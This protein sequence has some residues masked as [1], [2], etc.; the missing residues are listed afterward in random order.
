MLVETFSGDFL[1]ASKIVAYSIEPNGGKDTHVITA[2]T[3]KTMSFYTVAS[4][5]TKALAASGM[6]RLARLLAD[7]GRALITQDDI[8]CKSEGFIDGNWVGRA[9][10]A[11]VRDAGGQYAFSAE[12]MKWREDDGSILAEHGEDGSLR[13][14]WNFTE[15]GWR[16]GMARREEPPRFM[17]GAGPQKIVPDPNAPALKYRLGWKNDKGEQKYDAEGD[18]NDF[19]SVKSLC[20]DLRERAF[21]RTGRSD[22]NVYLVEDDGSLTRM[23]D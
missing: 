9:L 13:L 21:V 4:F 20:D 1:T 6:R 7:P 5:E 18:D 15:G 22:Y 14:T 10:M 11:C 12:E 19:D 2:H 23:E 8:H 3:R 17:G 16:R